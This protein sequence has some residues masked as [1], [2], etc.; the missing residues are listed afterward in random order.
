MNTFFEVPANGAG[1][2]PGSS[3]SSRISRKLSQISRA[4][5]KDDGLRSTVVAR[6]AGEVD[7]GM[8]VGASKPPSLNLICALHFRRV[9]ALPVLDR[10]VPR[11]QF[12]PRMWGCCKPE[13]GRQKQR[14]ASVREDACQE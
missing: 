12:E 9:C 3:S 6:V 7:G 8:G 11:K 14:V 2:T 13:R 5:A 1:T 4:D 10:R